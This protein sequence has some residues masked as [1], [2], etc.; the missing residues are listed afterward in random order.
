MSSWQV[1]ARKWDNKEFVDLLY[2]SALVRPQ[3]AFRNRADK[4]LWLRIGYINFLRW[5]QLR[6]FESPSQILGNSISSYTSSTDVI[7]L[8]VKRTGDIGCCWFVSITSSSAVLYSFFIIYSV[9]W[10]SP[11]LAS[12]AYILFHISLL[13]CSFP[14]SCEIPLLLLLVILM[15]M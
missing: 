7:P 11:C 3:R 15:C 10:M 13:Y 9:D 8:I 5:F 14:F 4:H 2:H 12:F 1:K 6:C